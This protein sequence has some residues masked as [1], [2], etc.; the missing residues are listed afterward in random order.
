MLVYRG[1]HR[2]EQGSGTK[3]LAGT[4]SD[5]DR[6]LAIGW[7]AVW[8]PWPVNVDLTTDSAAARAV[9]P[10][11]SVETGGLF[12]DAEGKLCGYQLIRVTNVAALMQ[13]VNAVVSLA[14]QAKGLHQGK[15]Q[16]GRQHE[17]DDE[18]VERLTDSLRA[19][20]PLLRLRGACLELALPCSDGDHAKLREAI[21]DDVLQNLVSELTRGARYEGDEAKLFEL[22]LADPAVVKEA[23][24]A[25]PTFR[26][27]R[28]NDLAILR[29]GPVTRVVLGVAGRERAVFRKASNG[30]Y[31]PELMQ[32]LLERKTP[33]DGVVSEAA[34]LKRFAEFR[35]REPVPADAAAS[36]P[37]S[38]PSDR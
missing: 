3:D 4:I 16:L 2:R 21:F 9:R 13:K 35:E 26:F 29:D 36:R 38:R 11:V 1:L 15:L 28:D 31:E 27:A 18:T 17:V 30:R 23:L 33:I 22:P 12:R 7:F 10:H 6:A 20:N 5:L 25:L 34:L 19:G 37:G 14:I 8:D 24:A 32:A